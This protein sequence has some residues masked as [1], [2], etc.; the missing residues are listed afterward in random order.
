MTLFLALHSVPA[1]PAI[2]QSL[3]SRLGRRLY[4]LVYSLT[5]LASLAWVFYAAFALDYVELWPPAAWQTW[6][7]LVLSSVALFVLVAGLLHN[8][9]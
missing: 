1:V 6:I 8:S 5:S 9:R 3:V 4:L 2:R 7:A